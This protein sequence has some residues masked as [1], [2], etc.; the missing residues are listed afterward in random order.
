M[1]KL[2]S[3]PHLSGRFHGSCVSTVAHGNGRVS[4]YVNTWASGADK[5]L[6]GGW[7]Q[8]IHG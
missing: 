5:Y 6:L 3:F 2:F 7:W 1:E 8:V 4:G